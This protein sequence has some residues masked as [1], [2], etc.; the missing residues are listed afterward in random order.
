MISKGLKLR[1]FKVTTSVNAS[2]TVDDFKANEYSL[3]LTDIQM[4]QMNGYELYRKLHEIDAKMK[5]CFLTGHNE[6]SEEFRTYYPNMD[7]KCF[8]NKPIRL[9][10]LADRLSSI[11]DT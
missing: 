2:K 1:G 10:Q 9:N 11:L 7:E 8:V 4:P 3:L 5:V 6:Y